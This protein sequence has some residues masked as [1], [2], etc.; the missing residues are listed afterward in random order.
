MAFFFL[1]NPVISTIRSTTIIITIR[2][3]RKGPAVIILVTC[4]VAEIAVI[5]PETP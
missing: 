1:D 2:P 5:F 3:R 4:G